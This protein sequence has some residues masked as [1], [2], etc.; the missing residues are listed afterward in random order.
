LSA[1]SAGSHPNH[2]PLSNKQQPPVTVTG[3]APWAIQPKQASLPHQQPPL[4][5]TGVAPWAM[6]QQ[7]LVKKIP[8]SSTQRTTTVPDVNVSDHSNVDSWNK[9]TVH[10][11]TG[12]DYV[13]ANL[14][15]IKP[16]VEE[17]GA[18]SWSKAQM[19]ETPTLLPNLKFHDLVFGHELGSGAFGSVKYARLIDKSKTRSHWAEYAVK[20][21]S[22]EKIREMGYETSIQREIAVLHVLSHPGIA[23]LISSFHFNDGA[24]LVLEYASRG[25]LHTLLHKHGSLD[26]ESTRFVIGEIIATLSRYAVTNIKS[27]DIEYSQVIFSRQL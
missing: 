1:T 2:Y 20:V 3:V 8:P 19:A 24:Y 12:Y 22:T 11:N 10:F 27:S 18:S 16:P 7:K 14:A 15:K 23:R 26:I 21:V 17:E 4:T 6:Q 5:V 25:D 9:V 13:M